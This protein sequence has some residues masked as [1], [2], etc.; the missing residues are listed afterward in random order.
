[1][2]PEVGDDRLRSGLQ[3]V[4]GV[5][6]SLDPVGTE[7][8]VALVVVLHRDR[9]TVVLPA[10]GLDRQPM[11]GEEEVDAVAMEAVVDQRPRQV[12]GLAEGEEEQLEVGARASGDGEVWDAVAGEL[13]LAQ[14][15]TEKAGFDSAADVLNRARRGGDGDAVT[16]SDVARGEDARAVDLQSGP[17]LA[18]NGGTEEDVDRAGD[19]A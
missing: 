11:V 12:V 4:A 17:L 19:R 13:R 15:A 10:V 3:L 14:R 1:M 7:P 2:T 9:P 5:A 6:T 16:L 18:T 8:E